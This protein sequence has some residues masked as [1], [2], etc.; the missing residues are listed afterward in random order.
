M[1]A[2]LRLIS[3]SNK[4][5][6]HAH[7][8]GLQCRPFCLSLVGGETDSPPSV[9]AA[10]RSFTHLHAA[11]KIK[12]RPDASATGDFAPADDA[13]W[14]VRLAVIGTGQLTRNTA[15]CVGLADRQPQRPALARK[16]LRTVLAR[17]SGDDSLT[18][19]VPIRC[20]GN[21]SLTVCGAESRAL[22]PCPGGERR[23]VCRSAPRLSPALVTLR[24]PRPPNQRG[25]G[26]LF[27]QWTSGRGSAFG[28]RDEGRRDFL[29]KGASMSMQGQGGAQ[30]PESPQEPTPDEPVQTPDEPA[31]APEAP[32]MPEDPHR[33]PSQSP[34]DES[35]ATPS[36]RR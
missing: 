14:V 30:E 33:D 21:R 8:V 20:D 22:A 23:R 9:A 13:L 27:Y 31:T 34:P 4:P 5:Q 29:T 32:T 15:L 7:P 12:W 11:D 17:R 19:G 26:P 3:S 36:Q 35:R 16:L 28:S 18:S 6:I 1:A 24:F 10:N 2:R 25:G